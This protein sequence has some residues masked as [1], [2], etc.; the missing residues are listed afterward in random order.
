M[1]NAQEL[2][3]MNVN[4]VMSMTQLGRTKIYYLEKQGNFPKRRKLGGKTIAWFYHEIQEWL[5]KLESES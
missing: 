1:Q 2:R 5:R 3:M 4:E